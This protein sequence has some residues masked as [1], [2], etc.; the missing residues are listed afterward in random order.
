MRV[1]GDFKIYVTKVTWGKT[2]VMV[3]RNQCY[4]LV[5]DSSLCP[6]VSIHPDLLPY[7]VLQCYYVNSHYSHGHRD[8]LSGK[9]RQTEP[10]LKCLTKSFCFFMVRTFLNSQSKK[11]HYVKHRLT[12][13]TLDNYVTESFNF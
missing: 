12:Y 9:R 10:C 4:L 11:T 2:V 7:K 13:N 6:Q 3:E 8:R 5:E 1:E